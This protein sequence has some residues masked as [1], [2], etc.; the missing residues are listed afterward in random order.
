MGVDIALSAAGQPARE[1]LLWLEGVRRGAR[2]VLLAALPL[3]F[4]L[5]A[6]HVRSHAPYSSSSNFAYYLGLVGGALMLA[7]LIYPLRKR[8]RILQAL[9]PLRIWFRFH[10]VAG[11]LGPLL[12]LFHSTFHVR[13]VNAAVALA[14]MLL[15]AASGIVGRFIYREI[16]RGLYGSRMTHEELQQ[17]LDKQLKE[18]QSSSVLPREV[19]QEIESFARL[20][21]CVPE[22]RWRRVAH[23]V[24]LGVRRRLAGR[25][26]RRTMAK[27]ALS[28]R[29]VL[30]GTLADLDQLL[31]NID[32]T[33]KAAQ[34]TAQFSTYERLF[35][36]WHAVHVPFLFMLLIT[37]LVHVVAVHAY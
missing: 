15:V 28:S 24:S 11:F 14:S 23:F 17:S 32:A 5:A 22:G 12:V 29:T 19:K 30:N 13:S 33:L 25:R 8:I 7:L 10:M 16:H 6:W 3:G 36:Q 2:F 21:S 31:L 35:S 26:A 9:G 20:V 1:T 27:H 34:T 37:A 4:L 18:V